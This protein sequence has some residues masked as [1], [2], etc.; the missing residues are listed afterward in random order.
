MPFFCD[1]CM[2]NNNNNYR[3]NGSR[4]KDSGFTAARSTDPLRQS[5][6][7]QGTAVHNLPVLFSRILHTVLGGFAGDLYY[8]RY[9]GGG[10]LEKNMAK[11][12]PL[13]KRKI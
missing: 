8:A 2:V 4:A 6:S 5:A 7:A 10:G 1:G 9:Y 3:S 11:W 12:K 13:K